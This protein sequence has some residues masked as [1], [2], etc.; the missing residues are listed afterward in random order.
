MRVYSTRNN[1]QRMI[2]LVNSRVTVQPCSMDISGDVISLMKIIN[3]KIH[4]I[5][6]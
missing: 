6:H 3:K 4:N 5:D 1:L 2:D